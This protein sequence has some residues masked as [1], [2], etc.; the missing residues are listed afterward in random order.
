[1]TDAEM[2]RLAVMIGRE[3]YRAHEKIVLTTMLSTIYAVLF[4]FGVLL[5]VRLA[6]WI[7]KK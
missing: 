7:V 6:K 3:V 5:F 4:L 1:M 2:Q